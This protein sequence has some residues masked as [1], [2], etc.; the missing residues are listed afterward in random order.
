MSND[1]DQ[2]E[3][4]RSVYQRVAHLFPESPVSR[5]PPGLRSGVNLHE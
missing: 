4:E 1:E 3:N 5:V 2:R